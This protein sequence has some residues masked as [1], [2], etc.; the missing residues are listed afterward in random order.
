MNAIFNCSN[1]TKYPD[2]TNIA[3]ATTVATA[4]KSRDTNQASSSFRARAWSIPL[5]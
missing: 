4:R 5:M 1:H 3:K 2:N